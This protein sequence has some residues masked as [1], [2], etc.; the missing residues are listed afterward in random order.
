[1]LFKFI[2]EVVDE[3]IGNSLVYI[4]EALKMSEALAGV[5]LIAF[6]NGA[7]DIIVSLVSTNGDADSA[8]AYNIGCLLG[9]GLFVCTV[10]M[11]LVI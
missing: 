4:A 5:T 8:I 11:F 3:Y 1:M 10:M 7:S 2:I 6:A 9:D